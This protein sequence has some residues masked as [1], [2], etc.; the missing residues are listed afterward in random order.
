M[1]IATAVH[2]VGLQVG[3]AFI[4]NDTAALPVL[5]KLVEIIKHL[6]EDRLAREPDQPL[7]PMVLRLLGAVDRGDRT[8]MKALLAALETADT[9]VLDAAHEIGWRMITFMTTKMATAALSD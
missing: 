6:D 8:E 1:P 4:Q 5:S 7:K 3:M 2:N 9:S